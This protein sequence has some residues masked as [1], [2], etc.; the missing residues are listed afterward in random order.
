MRFSKTTGAIPGALLLFSAAALNA[1]AQVT[2]T[3]TGNNFND[4]YGTGVTDSNFVSA[5]F[6]FADALPDELDAV[7]EIGSLLNWTVSDGSNTLSQSNGDVLALADLSTNA[8]G[9]IDSWYFLADSG[10]P[11][12]WLE[13]ASENNGIVTDLS[14]FWLTQ[15][16]AA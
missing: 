9:A 4:I 8:S 7:N 14:E 13:I 2:Y 6:T 16:D 10:S 15:S 5:S 1:S 3:Y 12:N 11:P